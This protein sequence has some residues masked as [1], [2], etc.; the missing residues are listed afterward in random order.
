MPA[1]I[2]DLAPPEAAGRYNGLGVLAFTTGF[3]LGPVGGAA[4]LAHWGTG[5]FTAMILA[6][7][8]A[9]L[10]ALRLSR[11]LPAGVNQIELPAAGNKPDGDYLPAA[12]TLDGSGMA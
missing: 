5:L 2:N 4:A 10:A 6:C 8:V 11:H 7:L 9:A 1:I 3:L 12:A